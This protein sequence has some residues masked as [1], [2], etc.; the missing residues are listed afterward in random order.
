MTA[1]S[2]DPDEAMVHAMCAAAD[3]GDAERFASYFAE[4]AVYRFAN[5][6]PITGRSAIARATASAV[7]LVWPVHHQVD[8]VAKVGAQ[9]FCRF[10]IQVEKPDGST[11]SMPFVTVIEQRNGL[12]VDYR[13][14][15]D[16]TPGLR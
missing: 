5:Q 1:P 10:T 6:E 12:I 8:Q 14:H 3:A 15:M 11:L 16:I 7:H 13:V 2:R 4:T 9:L